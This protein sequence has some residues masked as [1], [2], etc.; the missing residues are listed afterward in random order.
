MDISNYL[1]DYLKT[2]IEVNYID[3]LIVRISKFVISLSAEELLD[4]DLIK[5]FWIVIEEFE[6]MS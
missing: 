3:S 2:L 5:C 4:W 1:T 6:M